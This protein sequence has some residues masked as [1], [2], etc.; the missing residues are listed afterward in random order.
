MLAYWRPWSLVDHLAWLALLQRH[1]QRREREFSG[2]G[3]A[4]GPAI[5]RL[6]QASSTT[7]R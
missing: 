6:L 1:V 4:D 2:H 7:A 3:L 5:T